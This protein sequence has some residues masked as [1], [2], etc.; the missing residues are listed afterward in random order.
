MNLG[1]VLLGSFS[2]LATALPRK[3]VRK[4]ADK[5][6]KKNKR[7]NMKNT[8]NTFLKVHILMFPFR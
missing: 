3:D 7:A 2:I 5:E 1:S 6:R 4:G 8:V